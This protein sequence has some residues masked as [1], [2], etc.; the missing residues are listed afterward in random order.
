MRFRGGYDIEFHGKPEGFLEE[1][2]F[3][4]NLYLPLESKSFNFSVLC[5][6]HGQ[7]V[8]LGDVLAKDPDNYDVPLLSP[9]DG[10]VDLE[11]TP[12]HI[13]LESLSA[14]DAKPY[15]YHDDREHIHKKM[16][17]AGFKRYKLLNLGAW[18]YIKEV[19]T[20]R[21]PDTL[22]TPQAVIVSTMHLEPF[23]VRGDVLLKEYLRQ[24]TR[25]LEHLQSLLEYQ[26]IYLTFPKIKTDFAVKIKEQIRGYAWV[27]LIEVPLKY[28][29]DNFRILSRHLGLKSSQGAVWGVDVE[30][31]LA[32]DNALTTSRPCVERVISIA[33]SGANRALHL[34]LM[35]G[36]PISSIKDAYAME[37]A[38]AVDGGLLTGRLLTDDAK[39]VPAECKGITFVSELL[40]REF[41]GWL[42]PGFDR[43]S[44]SNC[45]MS[46]LCSLFPE[47]V[48]NAIRGEVRPCVSCGFCE[49]VCPAGIMPHRLHKLIYQDDIDAVD[50]FRIDLCVECGLCSFVCPSK[51]ELMHQF[52]EM[53]QSILKEKEA[54]AAEAAKKAA[55][56][57]SAPTESV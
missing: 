33:G 51:I 28:P 16:G 53:K 17:P 12:G 56:E 18:E 32:I 47:R 37:N 22:S 3:P 43:Q 25:G 34:R 31:V 48:T 10:E 20:G 29:Y 24:F 38:I 40:S 30:G 39:G 5:V 23:L 42:R 41:L 6:S 2:A 46:S 55:I 15:T 14:D 36:Y 1:A 54:A 4:E 13:T 49:E 19:D 9:C 26:P 45:F 21:L 11:K 7:R 44:Y 52:R 8:A 35:A 27:K 57:S 50:Q